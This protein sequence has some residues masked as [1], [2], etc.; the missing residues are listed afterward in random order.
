MYTHNASILELLKNGATIKLI[1]DSITA[2]GGSSDN[3]RSED[4]FLTIGDKEFRRQLEQKCWASLFANYISDKFPKC[5]IINDGC[6]DITS[7]DLKAQG[8]SL[9]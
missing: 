2:G 6:S 9:Y 8:W 5:K 3:N 4:I 7:A 1:G